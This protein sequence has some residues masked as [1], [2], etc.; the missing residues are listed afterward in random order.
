MTKPIISF[1]II[2]LSLGFV[3]FY[4][5]PAYNRNIESRTDIESLTKILSESGEIE[6]LIG[7]TKTELGSIEQAGLDR[8]EVF[9]PEK[10]DPIRFANNIQ[11]IGRKNRI[12]LTD[13][14]VEGQ[15]VGFEGNGASSAVS[16][17]QG[18][19]NTIS[20]GS[21]IDK[22][23]GVPMTQSG[24]G[25][26]LAGGKYAT[27]KANFSFTSTFETFQLFLND[28]EESLG[29]IDVTALSFSS[30]AGSVSVNRSD[31]SQL[32]IYQY[33]MAIETYSLK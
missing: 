29:V 12:I 5:V 21:Q 27:T 32:P 15:G 25:G 19:I 6:D 9:L 33:T 16:A 2:I 24:Q 14:K 22:A 10:I 31:T 4:V 7:K 13:I 23:L 8:F 28:L 1:T 17:T 11:Y 30:V 26:A 18:L 20:L 3:F